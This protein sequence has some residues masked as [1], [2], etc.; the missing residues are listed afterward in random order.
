MTHSR[1]FAKARQQSA[2][3]VQRENSQGQW[4]F[5]AGA[6]DKATAIALTE[7]YALSSYQAL[8]VIDAQ[9]GIVVY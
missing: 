8:R 2:F 5:V 6:S 9:T 7:M 3:K 4:T 1:S